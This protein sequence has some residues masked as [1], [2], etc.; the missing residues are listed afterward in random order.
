VHPGIGSQARLAL[1]APGAGLTEVILPLLVNDLAAPGTGAV[2][3]V[4]DDYHL[5][6]EPA[7]HQAVSYLLERAPPSL[8]L[9]IAGRQDPPLPLARLRARGQLGEIRAA[10]LRF[11]ADEAGASLT[12]ALTVP[13]SDEDTE[14]LRARTEGWPAAMHLATLSLRSGGD[15]RAFIDAFAG[16]D[17]HVADYPTSEVLASLEPA[18][19]AF[20]I[21]TSILDRVTDSLCDAV[22]GRE[23][24]AA[25][26]HALEQSNQRSCRSTPADGGTATARCSPTSCGCSPA[27]RRRRRSRTATP[28]RAAG[29]ATTA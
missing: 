10:D 21:D 12:D 7:V 3:Q 15:P 24:S 18:I 29:T 26:L 1:R 16:D 9:V 25:I 5:I 13:L 20:L 28:A 2:T 11:T 14:R 27:P 23:D 19:R 6:T 22:R 8:R 17:R 4:L